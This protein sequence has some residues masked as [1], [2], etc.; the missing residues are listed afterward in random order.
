ME[1]RMQSRS[2]AKNGPTTG[3]LLTA[4]GAA[5]AA[6]LALPNPAYADEVTLPPMPVAV[7]VTNGD[8][9]FLV[10]HA[11]G[12]QNYVCLP[13]GSGVAFV[14]FTPEATLSNDDDK[15]VI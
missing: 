7:Q 1:N 4:C 15:Q 5:L 12:T 10:G 6:A 14:L 2:S 9:P 3:I 13:S 8:I 11:I